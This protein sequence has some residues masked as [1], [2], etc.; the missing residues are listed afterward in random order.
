MMDSYTNAASK[1]GA[2]RGHKGVQSCFAA[3]ASAAKP[4]AKSTKETKPSAAETPPATAAAQA[5]TPT[6]TK[7]TA[8]NV[9]QAPGGGPGMG[10]TCGSNQRPGDDQRRIG[11]DAKHAQ[12]SSRP[13]R[14]G[15]TVLRRSS[16]VPGHRSIHNEDENQTRAR[17]VQIS[18]REGAVNGRSG[19]RWKMSDGSLDSERN[20]ADDVDPGEPIAELAGFEYD[21][22]PSPLE[23]IRR[24]TAAQV[25]SF[26][27]D[28]PF[29]VL[30]EFW[31][32]VMGLFSSKKTERMPG[33]EGKTS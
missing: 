24:T 28:M 19:G 22:S 7:T 11:V 27:F 23:R 16:P 12:D 2:C 25:A 30:K 26:A 14:H 21:V 6:A 8:A 33:D 3:D 31:F 15:R 17:G 10:A 29:V 32:I 20:D 1:A 18:I 9:A 5:T 4:T 13:L